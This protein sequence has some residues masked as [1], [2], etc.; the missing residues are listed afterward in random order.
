MAHQDWHAYAFRAMGSEIVLWVDTD[1]YP[2]GTFRQGQRLFSE[3]EQRLSRFIPESELS[4]LNQRTGQWVQV[5]PLLYQIAETALGLA[6]DTDGLF[7]PTILHALERAGYDRSFERMDEE[8]HRILPPARASANIR[9]VRLDHAQ[10]AIW[11]PHEVGLDLGGIAKSYV[12][13]QVGNFLRSHGPCLVDAGGDIVA[14]DAPRGLPGWPVAIAIP[15]SAQDEPENGLTLMLANNALATSG[16]DYRRWVHQG[17]KQHH[18][19]DPRTGLPA[20]SDLLTATVL[21]DDA[22]VADVWATASLIN[23]AVIG[24]LAL[25]RR[26]LGGVLIGSNRNATITQTL[27]TRITWQS[28]T[29]RLKLVLQESI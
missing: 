15:A 6:Q 12:A 9:G 4:R 11:L 23:G 8:N 3:A 18:I 29:L 19:I 24:A 21:A 13:Q 5:S 7:D 16:V 2:A 17:R 14:G 1:E 10:R 28:P 26:N 20:E 27:L 25:T 22:S